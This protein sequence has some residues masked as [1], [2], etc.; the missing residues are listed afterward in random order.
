MKASIAALLVV[1]SG[2]SNPSKTAHDEHVD[3]VDCLK[4]DWYP[5]VTD[6]KQPRVHVTVQY[7]DHTTAYKPKD[8]CMSIDGRPLLSTVDRA[9][10]IPRLE[11]KEPMTWKGTVSPGKHELGSHLRS[12]AESSDGARMDQMAHDVHSFEATEGMVLEITATS[13]EGKLTITTK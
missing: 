8:M 12:V 13:P 6:P 4:K 5:G 7:E 9:A 1:V 11:K 2:C 3:Y 10:V